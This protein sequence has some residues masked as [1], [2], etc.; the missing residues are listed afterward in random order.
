M[1]GAQRPVPGARRSGH[2]AGRRLGRRSARGAEGR[3]TLPRRGVLNQLS[4]RESFYSSGRKCIGCAGSS[5]PPRR[6][7]GRASLHGRE[8]QPGLALLR[9]AQWQGRCGRRRDP[10]GDQRDDGPAGYVP[11]S[12]PPSWKSC[13]R[14][15]NPT[16]PSRHPVSSMRSAQPLA[17]EA[18][19]AMAAHARG[20]GG[21]GRGRSNDALIDLRRAQITWTE[22]SAPHEVARVREQVGLACRALGDEDTARLEPEAARKG[23]EELGSGDRSGSAGFVAWRHPTRQRERA[24]GA[25]T[26]RCLRRVAAGKTNRDIA[27]ELFISEHTV[28]RH[29]QNIFAKLDVSSRTAATAFAFE[30]DL[31]LGRRVVIFHQSLAAT[32]MVGLSDARRISRPVGFACGRKDPQTGGDVSVRCGSAPDQRMRKRL[33]PV[34]RSS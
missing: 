14:T 5:P 17:C 7:Y 15:E 21:P 4:V 27:A 23:F 22:L 20:A 8:A 18:V 25:R 28:A 34:A 26:R 9:L 6:H 3:R 31:V 16:L 19:E 24:D 11:G 13:S 33:S 29:I 10:S 32:K 2:A 30:H 12:S 1:V